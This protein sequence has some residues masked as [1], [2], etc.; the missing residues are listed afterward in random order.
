MFC[1]ISLPL[2]GFF[3]HSRRS[4]VELLVANGSGSQKGSE[5]GATGSHKA[6][7]GYSNFL[8]KQLWLSQKQNIIEGTNETLKE[9]G[10]TK[11]VIDWTSHAW[12]VSLC[13]PGS[14]DLLAKYDCL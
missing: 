14:L 8:A 11:H 6:I 12:R 13:C 3:C 9:V 1:D 7:P 5:V 10:N 4:T 2:N